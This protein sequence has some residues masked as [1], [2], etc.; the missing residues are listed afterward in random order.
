MEGPDHHWENYPLN[1]NATWCVQLFGEFSKM[2]R[3]WATLAQ[4]WPAVNPKIAAN[5]G[6]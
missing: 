3:F 5:V 2:V 6:F 4:F 1:P